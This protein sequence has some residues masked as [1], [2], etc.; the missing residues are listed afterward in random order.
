MHPEV[1]A[2][3]P[4]RATESGLVAEL[5]AHWKRSGWREDED[6]V[7]P[8]PLMGEPLDPSALLRRFK[9]ARVR[10]KKRARPAKSV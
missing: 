5:E 8:N 7:F 4:V 10:M 6:L 1:E 2:R 3:K 9:E